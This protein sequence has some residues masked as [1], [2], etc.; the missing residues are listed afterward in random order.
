VE[1]VVGGK[2]LVCCNQNGGF[3]EHAGDTEQLKKA[4]FNSMQHL[5][6]IELIKSDQKHVVGWTMPAEMKIR[7]T[8]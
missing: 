4:N 5:S 7:W 1:H 3:K 2:E 6:S 8:K